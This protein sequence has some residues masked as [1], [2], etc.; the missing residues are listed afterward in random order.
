MN[1]TRVGMVD[2]LSNKYDS[3]DCKAKLYF[4]VTNFTIVLSYV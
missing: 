4:Y 3:M 2:K 1:D